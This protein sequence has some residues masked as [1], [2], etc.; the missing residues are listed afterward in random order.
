MCAVLLPPGDNPIAVNNN[1]YYSANTHFFYFSLCSTLLLYYEV[2][3]LNTVKK[4]AMKL[5]QYEFLVH[6]SLKNTR[7]LELHA[8]FSSSVHGEEKGTDLLFLACDSLEE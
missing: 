4:F 6:I 2:F 8:A 7:C 5:L 3:L 1:Y